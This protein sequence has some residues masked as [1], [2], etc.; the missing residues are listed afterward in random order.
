MLDGVQGTQNP[1]NILVRAII[2]GFGLRIGAEL[3]KFVS[4]KAA[5][6]FPE[7]N[8][9]DEE[10]KADGERAEHEGGSE[11]DDDDGLPG[12]SPDPPNV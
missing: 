9:E 7:R 10:Q 6:L 8:E 3:G 5:E 2:T 4:K 1:M 12:I 11:D